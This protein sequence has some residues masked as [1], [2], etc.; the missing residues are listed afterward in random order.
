MFVIQYIPYYRIYKRMPLETN[1]NMLESSAKQMIFAY[2]RMPVETNKNM[3][4][5]P[6]K[7]M[8]FAYKR[9]RLKIRL[10]GTQPNIFPFSLFN[11]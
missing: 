3:L 2:K 11:A 4:E 6:A 7:Q 9:M 5:S 10:Y 8:I 1:K